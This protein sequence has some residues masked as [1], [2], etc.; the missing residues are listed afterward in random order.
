MVALNTTRARVAIVAGARTPFVKMGGALRDVHV[1]DLAKVAMQETLYRAGWYADRL[2]EVILG[3]VVM[4][5]D[6][7]NLGRVSALWAGIPHRVPA[8]TVQRNCASGIEAIAD[9]AAKIRAGQ[10][11]DRLLDLAEDPLCLGRLVLGT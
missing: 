8:L 9:A 4:P 2:D 10:G 6:A 3:N 1:A 5:A 7:T 11:G